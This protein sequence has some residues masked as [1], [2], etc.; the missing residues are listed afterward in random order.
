[1]SG[2]GSNAKVHV[3]EKIKELSTF[4]WE[5]G[6]CGYFVKR[7]NYDANVEKFKEQNAESGEFEGQCNGIF[8]WTI[9]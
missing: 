6:P 5:E 7:K 2:G 9:D 8:L 4:E 1:M 3:P